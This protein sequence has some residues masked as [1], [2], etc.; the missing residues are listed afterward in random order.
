MSKLQARVPWTRIKKG[1]RGVGRGPRGAVNQSTWMAL[2]PTKRALRL[3][4]RSF[5]D[6]TESG[7]LAVLRVANQPVVAAFLR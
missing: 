4:G 5:A 2:A 7:V 3:A 1:R 6:K